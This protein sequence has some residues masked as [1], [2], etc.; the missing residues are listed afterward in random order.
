MSRRAARTPTVPSEINEA[1]YDE[2]ARAE[3]A[4]WR[5]TMMKG[6]NLFDRGARGV[7]T[8]IN[9]I[10][11]DR[12]HAVITGVMEGMTRA[13]ITGSDLVAP[14]PLTG[15]P[16]SEREER[17]KGLIGTYRAAAAAEGGAAG[18]GGFALS[19]AEFPVLLTTKIKLL[20]DI[21]AAYG[22]DGSELGERLYIM[23][24]FQLAF[25]GAAHRQDILAGLDGWDR[26]V[27]ERPASLDD[28][29]W[30]KFQQEYRDYIDLAKMA[31][32]IPVIGAPVGA[33][34]NY[35]LVGRLGTTAINA[36]RL[37]WFGV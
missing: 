33:V 34:V 35:R 31:Q 26:R 23:S 19:L 6:P 2:R 20:F 28:V 22:H 1:A 29:D 17:A 7:Q 18:A 15:A 21:A 30:R 32:L 5:A 12:V 37:R 3:L 13:I 8:K 25:S 27:A 24:I 9:N 14:K 16:L 11:P 36:Y 10:I 4:A